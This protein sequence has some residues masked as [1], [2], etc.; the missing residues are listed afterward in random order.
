MKEIIRKV[1]AARSQKI[2]GPV[3][4]GG[5]AENIHGYT[6]SIWNKLSDKEKVKVNALYEMFYDSFNYHPAMVKD[7]MF[8][9]YRKTVAHNHA[10]LAVWAYKD[11]KCVHSWVKAQGIG[12]G[13]VFKYCNKCG[14]TK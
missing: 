8:N 6:K 5:T 14:A 3:V 1:K 12:G 9:E 4:K 13:A 10:L 2:I 11:E 7:K